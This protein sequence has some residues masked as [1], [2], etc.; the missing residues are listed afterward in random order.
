MFYSDIQQDFLDDIDCL[1]AWSKELQ[2]DID[3]DICPPMNGFYRGMLAA[4]KAQLESLERRYKKYYPYD[5]E[6]LEQS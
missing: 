6:L 4:Y 3:K 5:L 2:D 1:R